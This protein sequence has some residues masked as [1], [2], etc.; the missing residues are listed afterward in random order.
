[1]CQSF[2][3][4]LVVEEI[5]L[6]GYIAKLSFGHG[7]VGTDWQGR[8]QALDRLTHDYT[9]RSLTAQLFQAQRFR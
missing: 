4:L 9:F 2:T 7:L 6:G 5:D 3:R 1:M 8:R